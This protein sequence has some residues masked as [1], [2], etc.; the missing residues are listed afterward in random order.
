MQ[1]CLNSYYFP[2]AHLAMATK[3]CSCC[4]WEY[5]K[6]LPI[7]GTKHLMHAL[8]LCFFFSHLSLYPCPSLSYPSSLPHPSPLPR[9]KYSFLGF[10][11]P[12]SFSPFRSQ[13]KMMPPQR[14]LSWPPYLKYVL[15]VFPSHSIL[16]ISFRVLLIIFVCYLIIKQLFH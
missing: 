9:M 15:T 3:T 5:T 4:F 14:N 8:Y 2:L 1:I 12:V 6:I 7:P 11:H 16:L 13:F 10:L